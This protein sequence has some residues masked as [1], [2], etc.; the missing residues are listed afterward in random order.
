MSS[1]TNSAQTV[2]VSASDETELSTLAPV[3]LSPQRRIWLRFIRNR[4]GFWSLVLFLTLYAV[5]LAG[6]LISND[7]PLIAHYEGQWYFPILKDYPEASFGGDLPIKADYNDPFIKAQLSKGNNWV[8]YPLNPYYYDTLNYFS[9][10][11]HY[12]GAPSKEN[13][14]GTDIA[15]YDIAA[16]LLYGFRV[17]VTFALAPTIVGIALG[18]VIGA[19]QG[20][21]AGKVDL[22]GQRLIE[23]WHSM[24][25][26][27]LLIIFASVFEHS[28]ILLFVLLSLFAWISTSD[29]VRAEVLRNRQLDYI[30]AAQAMGLSHWQI[31]KRHI[32]PNSLTSVITFLPF[33]MSAA[34]TALAAL[35]FLGLGVTAPAPSM[36]HLLNQGKANL[37]AWWI[38]LATFTVFLVTL[39]LLTFTGDALRAA[40]DPRVAHEDEPAPESQ[41]PSTATSV[42]LAAAQSQGFVRAVPRS[43][44]NV[45]ARLLAGLRQ[46]E[47]V[48]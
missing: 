43:S 24:P 19:V 26:L 41:A 34:I 33:R 32:L 27:Y 13:W 4:L 5:S 37:D 12:P 21:F 6:E 48:Q 7:R 9:A 1:P 46:R 22:V 38:S 23:I 16:R 25:E 17:S 30:K 39:L 28:F 44:V 47:V 10:T 15:G 14:L 35:D 2:L 29:Y 40:M 31:I 45:F 20:Y 8:I 11:E 3:T 42:L 18:V 36:G